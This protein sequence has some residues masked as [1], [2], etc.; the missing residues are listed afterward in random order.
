MVDNLLDEQTSYCSNVINPANMADLVVWF[1]FVVCLVPGCTSEM[2][3]VIADF[4]VDK[5]K[6]EVLEKP[7]IVITN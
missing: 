5:D 7:F 2:A 3:A 6:K 4:G 1:V